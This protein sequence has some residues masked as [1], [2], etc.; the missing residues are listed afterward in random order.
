M[1][2]CEKRS[3]QVCAL[4]HIDMESYSHCQNV[5]SRRLLSYTCEE[6]HILRSSAA[7]TLKTRYESS[8]A[9]VRPSAKLKT[10]V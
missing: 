2:I 10:K 3:I 1:K 5:V 6:I 9:M 8:G 4:L 7:N